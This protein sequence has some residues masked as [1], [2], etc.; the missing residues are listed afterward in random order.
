MARVTASHLQSDDFAQLVLQ[1][2]RHGSLK[3]ETSEVGDTKKK[4]FSIPRRGM[5]MIMSV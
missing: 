5:T 1:G 4:A 3:K 2:I